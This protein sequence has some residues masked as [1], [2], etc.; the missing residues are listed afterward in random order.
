MDDGGKVIVCILASGDQILNFSEHL[1]N[2]T[3]ATWSPDGERILSTGT[4]GEA[5]I[6]EVAH[7]RC[8]D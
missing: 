5:M 7:G 4:N 2:A 1:E 8:A 6:W 3:Y